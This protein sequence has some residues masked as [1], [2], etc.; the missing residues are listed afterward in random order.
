MIMGGMGLSER[1]K[2]SKKKYLG[3]MMVVKITRRRD[4]KKIRKKGMFDQTWEG[5]SSKVKSPR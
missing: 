3:K 4:L 1:M 5:I 2:F